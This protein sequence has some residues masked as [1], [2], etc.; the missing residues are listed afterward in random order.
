M[1]V[2][3]PERCGINENF[4][5]VTMLQWNLEHPATVERD[6]QRQA[7]LEKYQNL[8][9]PFIDHPE[10]GCRIFGYLDPEGHAC[11]K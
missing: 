3:Y 4:D 10:I 6:L 11:G 9:N 5:I 7:G 8:R 2:M 1:V